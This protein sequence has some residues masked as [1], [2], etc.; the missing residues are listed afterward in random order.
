MSNS[1]RA[2]LAPLVLASAIV[3][4]LVITSPFARAAN[5]TIAVTDTGFS[6]MSASILAGDTVTW[7]NDTADT[8][9]ITFLGGGPTPPAPIAAG[10]TGTAT[11]STEGTFQYRCSQDDVY[12]G[13]VVVDAAATATPTATQTPTDTPTPTSTTTG[14]PTNTPTSTPTVSP[15]S[16]RTSTPTATVSPTSTVAAATAIATP[17]PPATGVGQSSTA[18]P[19]LVVVLAAIA[20]AGGLGI[21]G[22]RALGRHR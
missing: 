12:V 3:I 16:T 9:T 10:A 20:L 13:S 8:C 18:G 22:A 5:V 19:A 4:A 2:L 14:T 21:L 7:D 11:F 15:T 1:L 17:R 6:P